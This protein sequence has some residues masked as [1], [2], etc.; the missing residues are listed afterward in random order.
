MNIKCPECSTNILLSKSNLE[1]SSSHVVCD[2]CGANITL[3]SDLP[4]ALKQIENDIGSMLDKAFK[5]N[6]HIKIK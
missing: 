5:G 3:E 1:K 6:K 2:S 4:N